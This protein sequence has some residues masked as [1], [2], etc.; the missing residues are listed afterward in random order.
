MRI[1]VGLP[2][3]ILPLRTAHVTPQPRVAWDDRCR[4]SSLSIQR[5]KITSTAISKRIT[6]STH[7][8]VGQHRFAT[9]P[10]PRG[11][12]VTGGRSG[13]AIW[14]LGCGAMAGFQRTPTS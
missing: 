2:D 1:V 6:K 4:A 14:T 5:R 13:W 7:S 8:Q 10:A 3:W 12:I 11:V 9:D